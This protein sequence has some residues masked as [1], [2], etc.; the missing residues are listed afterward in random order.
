[1]ISHRQLKGIFIKASYI[2]ILSWLLAPIGL[3]SIASAQDN[4]TAEANT[5][6]LGKSNPFSQAQYKKD[7]SRIFAKGVPPEEV[8]STLL[9]FTD[10]A[11]KTMDDLVCTES[12]TAGH[13]SASL[14]KAWEQ[15][16][17]PD[18]DGVC[19]IK[20]VYKGKGEPVGELWRF[21]LPCCDYPACTKTLWLVAE[22]I[23]YRFPVDTRESSIQIGDSPLRIHYSFA[24][25]QWTGRLPNENVGSG[26]SPLPNGGGA[27]GGGGKTGST[28]GQGCDPTKYGSIANGSTINQNFSNYVMSIGARETGFSDKEANTDFYNQIS[29]GGGSSP[30]IYDSNGK[31]VGYHNSNV[32]RGVNKEG[33]T[34]EQAQAK[35]GDYGYF[36]TNQNDVDHAI[37]LGVPPD[38][39]AAMNNGGG[40]GKYTV[41]QQAEATALYIQKLNPAAAE[42][43]ANGDYAKA[44]SLLNGKWPSLPGGKSHKSG[45][46][47]CANSFL[48]YT[49]SGS[50]T[51][52]AGTM[53]TGSTGG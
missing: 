19:K 20:Y 27:I 28:G 1:M 23:E 17:E 18:E 50:T 47:A 35:Y 26:S 40:N 34:L 24:V 44:N 4:N 9:N 10:Q 29:P 46:D 32:A 16:F 48:N 49:G 30:K 42:A 13:D 31:V 5:R 43:A 3:I 8:D 12:T 11:L 21:L 36:Q 39:A 22:E 37:K 25:P 33:L 53:P 14:K 38:K 15:T 51:A 52:D 7:V 6:V 41:E 45:N 2:I